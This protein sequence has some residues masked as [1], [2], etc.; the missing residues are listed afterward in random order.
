MPSMAQQCWLMPKLRLCL[1]SSPFHGP[2]EAKVASAQQ[3]VPCHPAARCRSCKQQWA[4][5]STMLRRHATLCPL[6]PLAAAAAAPQSAA[7][8]AAPRR[9]QHPRQQALSRMPCWSLGPA[10]SRP[11]MPPPAQSTCTAAAATVTAGGMGRA[12]RRIAVHNGCASRWG[13]GAGWSAAAW[14]LPPM[15]IIGR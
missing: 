6:R 9:R 3:P 13:W 2:N 15:G 7:L 5:P 12:T 4:S 8:L 14:A 1:L 11:Q 10:A